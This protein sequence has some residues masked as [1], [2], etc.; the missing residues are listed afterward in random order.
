MIHMVQDIPWSRTKS[1][2]SGHLG[3]R[4]A[5]ILLSKASRMLAF[6]SWG[7]ANLSTNIVTN[8]SEGLE[9]V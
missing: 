8:G 2:K 7:N 9:A 3:Y 4:G 5:T 6:V 1:T